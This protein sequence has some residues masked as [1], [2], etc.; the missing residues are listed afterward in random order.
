MDRESTNTR[1]Y[2][3]G[4]KVPRTVSPYEEEE[5]NSTTSDGRLKSSI[6]SNQHPAHHHLGYM[7][8]PPQAEQ[9]EDKEDRPPVL[10]RSKSIP[11]RASMKRTSSELQ[12]AE[13][14]QV[15][16]FRDYLM[17]SRIVDGITRQQEGTKDFHSRLVNDACLAHIIGVRNLS[18]EELKQFDNHHQRRGLPVATQQQDEWIRQVHHN[19][20]HLADMPTKA[21]IEPHS[22]K[23]F[24]E[25]SY[26][27]IQRD[28][29][30][31]LLEL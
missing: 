9:E 11:I 22:L 24:L 18:E 19:H 12:L 1:M 31:F 6:S 13:E 21:S 5:G 8:G 15:A 29:E 30:M 20:H 25:N 2:V 7:Y 3:R 16:D 10:E 26:S 4:L 17:F 23:M 27:E 28:D 14:K